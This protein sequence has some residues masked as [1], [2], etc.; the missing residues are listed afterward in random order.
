M[1]V[2]DILPK[3]LSSVY[4]FYDPNF[5]HL[6][7]GKFSALNEIC[8]VKKY[9]KISPLLKYYYMGFYIHS[10]PKMI[11]KSEYQTSYL[12]DIVIFPFDLLVYA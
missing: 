2:I 5:K 3:C 9:G 4:L 6:G 10:C 11:Y 12:L 7:L 8:W 1:G